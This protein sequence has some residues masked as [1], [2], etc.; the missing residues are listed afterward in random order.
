MSRLPVFPDKGR[1][2]LLV[3]LAL[4]I[5]LTVGVFWTSTMYEFGTLV[6]FFLGA[7][8]WIYVLPLVFIMRRKQQA[9]TAKG[10]LAVASLVVVANVVCLVCWF[11]GIRLGAEL[12]DKA[13]SR[14]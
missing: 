4:G 1:G 9:K 7:F 11:W 8:Q 5:A 14:R 12:I 13:F 2:S 6:F 3:G 10:I